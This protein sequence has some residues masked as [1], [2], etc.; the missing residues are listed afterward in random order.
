MPTARDLKHILNLEDYAFVNLLYTD[1]KL[2]DDWA[3]VADHCAAVAFVT[4]E[5]AVFRGIPRARRWRLVTTAACHDARKRLEKCPDDFALWEQEEFELYWARL[6]PDPELM[7]ALLPSFHLLEHPTD[8]QYHI[9][10]C[11]DL[12]RGGEIVRFKE[13]LDEME[14]RNP[15]PDPEVAAALGRPYWEVEREVGERVE[16]KFFE[17]L[18]ARKVKVEE[19]AAIPDVINLRVEARLTYEQKMVH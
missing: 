12:C 13:R 9:W 1:G 5:L 18:K 4:H 6:D 7:A 3:N 10:Y 2:T 15:D 16:Q 19:P 14:A 11:D 17:E 8:G